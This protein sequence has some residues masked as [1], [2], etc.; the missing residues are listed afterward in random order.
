[1][2][3]CMFTKIR[4]MG[5]RMTGQWIIDSAAMFM[6]QACLVLKHMEGKT[7]EGNMSHQK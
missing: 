1:M 7:S 6:V 2:C 4:P 5:D 3:T